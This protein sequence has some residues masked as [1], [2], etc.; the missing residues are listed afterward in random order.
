MWV[1]KFMLENNLDELS[2]D[3][4]AERNQDKRDRADEISASL[5]STENNAPR[6]ADGDGQVNENVDGTIV[7]RAVPQVIVR[8]HELQGIIDR[9]RKEQE[10]IERITA[11]AIRKYLNAQLVRV[12]RNVERIFDNLPQRIAVPA[13]KRS[14]ALMMN[15]TELCRLY[16]DGTLVRETGDYLRGFGIIGEAVVPSGCL[17]SSI[18]FAGITVRALTPDQADDLDD[19]EL[20][21]EELARLMEQ[22]IKTAISRGGDLTSATLKQTGS[23]DLRNPHA[24]QFLSGKQRDY[25]LNSVSATTKSL[26]SEKLGEVL[27]AG[28]TVDDLRARLSYSAVHRLGYWTSTKLEETVVEGSTWRHDY[29]LSSVRATQGGVPTSPRNTASG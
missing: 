21:S 10:E 20:A 17:H 18:E 29:P 8:S 15:G 14:V 3:A 27:A 5:S 1:W 9:A 25:W 11:R 28:A 6:D 12:L 13:F 23:F 16:P 2:P 19:W 7:T 26:L 4:L 24:E 22:P